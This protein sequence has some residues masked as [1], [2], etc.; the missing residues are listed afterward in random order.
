MTI[1]SAAK[2]S[3]PEAFNCHS[4]LMPEASFA[5]PAQTV[6]VQ[7]TKCHCFCIL[8]STF[9]LTK[10]PTI[11]RLNSSLTGTRIVPILLRL[12][13]FVIFRT[14]STNTYE[15]ELETFHCLNNCSATP[16]TK[17]DFLESKLP[18]GPTQAWETAFDSSIP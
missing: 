18:S 6:N 10:Y 11:N 16:Y 14:A 9:C 7:S 8:Q 1:L 2:R 15:P 3:L 17:S 5:P 4:M 12:H 13:L